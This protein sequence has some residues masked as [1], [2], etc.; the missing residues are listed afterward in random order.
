MLNKLIL[1]K[2][3]KVVLSLFVLAF[4]LQVIDLDFFSILVFFIAV[5]SVFVYR[6]RSLIIS[7][8]SK[9]VSP[10]SGSI[11]AIDFD[12]NKQM[13]Y[14]NVSLFDDSSFR[15]AQD[16]K[17]KIKSF[18]K[19]LNLPLNTYKSKT[20]NERMILEFKDIEVELLS[21]VCTNDLEINTS[22]SNTIGDEIGIF[23]QGEVILILNKDIKTTLVLGQK[24][25][26]GQ[27]IV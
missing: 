1:K 10:V 25:K 15:A 12:E 19:G 7:E 5:L 11:E 24:I 9:I 20:L 18:L 17:V 21:S 8:D 23:T 2:G 6:N 27:G 22:K 16:G 14:I 4:L 13:I 3:Q 26:A